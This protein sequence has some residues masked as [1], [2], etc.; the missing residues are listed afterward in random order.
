MIHTKVRQPDLARWRPKVFFFSPSEAL[1]GE[2]GGRLLN[3]SLGGVA[4]D[5]DAEERLN[6]GMRGAR[7]CGVLELLRVVVLVG[8]DAANVVALGADILVRGVS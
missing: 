6:V 5:E 2:A 7:R 1:S 3:S 8:P 4:G